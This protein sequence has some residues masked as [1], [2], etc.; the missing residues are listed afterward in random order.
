MLTRM[1]SE[2]VQNWRGTLGFLQ[3]ITGHALYP[4]RRF[5]SAGDYVLKWQES[6]QAE[7]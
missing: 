5:V 7:S 2:F 1:A 6:N 4:A 3:E